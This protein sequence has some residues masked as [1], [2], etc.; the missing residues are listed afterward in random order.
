MAGPPAEALSTAANEAELLVIGSR[1]LSG[2][3]GFFVG[4]VAQAAVAH[5]GRPVVL[6]RA[7]ESTEDE[8][9][10]D[11]AGMALT[12]PC[13]ELL[14]FAFSAAAQRGAR[15][16]V[17][18]GWH[19]PTAYSYS[20]GVL[21]PGLDVELADNEK[22]ALS[23]A[24]RPWRDKFPGVEVIEQSVIGRPAQHLMEAASDCSLVV[25]GRR[26]RHAAAGTHIGPVAHAVIHHCDAPIAVIPHEA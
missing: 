4:S 19:L 8:H 21:D 22:G 25:I 1:G 3:A 14:E 15:L 2:V 6:V 7:G 24:L 16:R 11:A 10:P 12:R 23:E 18:N 5:V 26:T 17:I 13:H 20:P 9:L